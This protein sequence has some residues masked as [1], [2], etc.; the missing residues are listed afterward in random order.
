M[1]TLAASISEESE[2][3]EDVI[4]PYLMQ[5]GFLDRTSKG[6]VATRFAY[7]YLGVEWDTVESNQQALF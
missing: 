4:E 6:R 1:D 2:T 5:K 3:L 7:S